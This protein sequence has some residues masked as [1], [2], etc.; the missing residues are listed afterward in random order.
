MLKCRHRRRCVSVWGSQRGGR[1]YE[2]IRCH[3]D[4]RDGV[5]GD[6]RATPDHSP[7]QI[8][9]LIGHPSEKKKEKFFF[10]TIIAPG[11]TTLTPWYNPLIICPLVQSPLP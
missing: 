3:G 1:D 8:F 7:P 10:D 5:W 11:Y 6:A 4:T 9:S 2:G